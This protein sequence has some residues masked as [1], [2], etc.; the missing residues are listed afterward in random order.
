MNNKL[1]LNIVI[2]YFVILSIVLVFQISK[3]KDDISAPT[4]SNQVTSEDRLDNAVVFNLGSPVI[5]VNKKQTLLEKTDSSQVPVVKGEN[6]YV[7][8]SFFK[9]AYGASVTG[10]ANAPSATIRMNN[11]AL[12]MDS[13]NASIVDNTREKKLD[14]NIK[15]F[16]DKGV[17]YVPITVFANAFNKYLY[18]YNGMVI[19]SNQENAFTNE[20]NTEFI[21]NLRTQVNDLPYV[22]TEENLREITNTSDKDELINKIGQAVGNN[23]QNNDNINVAG[24]LQKDRENLIKSDDTY[25]YCATDEGV[26]ILDYTNGLKHI[27]AIKLDAGFKPQKIELENNTLVVV[28]NLKENNSEVETGED[29]QRDPDTEKAIVYVYDVTNVNAPTQKR[30]VAVDGYAVDT[31]F[32]GDFVYL[33]ANSSVFDNYKEG[34][35]VAPSYTDSADGDAVTIMDFSNMQYFPEMGGDS[36]TVV[37]AINIADTKQ[38]TSAKSFLCAGD[39]ISLFGSNLYVAKNR[40]TAFDSS[41]KTENTRIYR[42]SLANGEFT[43]N[44]YGEVKGHP[45][46]NHSID[47]NNGYVRVVTSNVEGK[48]KKIVN[49]VYVLNNNMEISGEATKVANN[50][51]ISSVILT[52]DKIYLTPKEKGEP[53]YT[54]DM[55]NPLNPSGNGILKLSDGNIMLYPYGE[56]QI[57]TVDN[58]GDKLKINAFDISSKDNPKLLY[59]QELGGSNISSSVF[60]NPQAFMFDTEKNIFVLPVTIKSEED[61]SVTFNGAYIYSIYMDEGFERL[62]A[63]S[64]EGNI[65]TIFKKKGKLYCVTN[66]GISQGTFAE[67]DKM[68]GVKFI[69]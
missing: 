32:E 63:F 29:S 51:N 47:E 4:T 1:I 2:V 60:E 40:Y 14:Y 65:E 35:F 33:V 62:G 27:S 59:S 64:T 68:V 46:D 23:S 41:D 12:V 26:N 3:K 34:H 6:V 54:V 21:Q 39:N 30:K 55:S 57:V 36:Y 20:E 19:V 56:D 48:E 16:A 13:E 37:M 11:K 52:E 45:V 17:D 7:P 61:G 50:A 24:L 38:G 22:A 44:A 58:G 15:I 53:I 9:T 42:F 67:P 31:S 10:D 49:S 25:M 5:L 18:Y 66:R 43:R 8:L 28:G 69:K